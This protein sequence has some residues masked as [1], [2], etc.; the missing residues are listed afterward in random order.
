M[1]N[2]SAVKKGM[3]HILIPSASETKWTEFISVLASIINN[4]Q[5]EEVN[6][7]GGIQP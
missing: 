3:E 2:N 7:S 5:P 4:D 1:S 6:M